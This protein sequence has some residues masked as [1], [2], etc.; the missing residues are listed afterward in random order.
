MKNKSK[1]SA[2]NADTRR[3]TPVRFSKTAFAGIA[4]AVAIS[5]AV[6]WRLHTPVS[7]PPPDS[8]V[9]SAAQ[10]SPP[11][12]PGDSRATARPAAAHAPAPAAADS[13]P[14][15]ARDVPTQGARVRIVAS[16]QRPT[17][18]AAL[19]AQPWKIREEWRVL[20]ES[21]LNIGNAT[22]TTGKTPEE[23]E[24]PLFDG[25]SITLTHFRYRPQNAPNKGAF[26]GEVKGENTGHVLLSYVN[27]ALVGTIHIP[28][29]SRY[30]EIRNNTPDGGAVSQ[31]FLTQLDPAKMPTCGT[32]QPASAPGTQSAATALA[33][34]P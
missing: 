22:R 16:E 18:A 23:I 26:L 3:R 15:A 4:I 1:N 27:N 28:A 19:V 10:K 21:F 17:P 29:Q 12:T 33:R 2:P 7:A 25:E 34:V 32:C 9:S 13:A 24:F 5:V 11:S 20:S 30:Y 14:L 6:V 8:P 31:V